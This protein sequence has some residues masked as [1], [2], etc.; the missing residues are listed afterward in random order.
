MCQDP[1]VN[2]RCAEGAAARSL[3]STPYDIIAEGCEEAIA[4]LMDGEKAGRPIGESRF[5]THR[6]HTFD[7]FD[8]MSNVC[9][10][11]F[12]IYLVMCVCVF[13]TE[14]VFPAKKVVDFK[15]PVLQTLFLCT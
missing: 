4:Q 8:N 14:G 6:L 10:F 13:L 2:K 11:G 15:L 1:A 5:L 7:T 3:P 12:L 9:S